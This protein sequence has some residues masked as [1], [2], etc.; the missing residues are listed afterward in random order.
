MLSI[1]TKKTF[2]ERKEECEE[3]N[4]Q[5]PYRILHSTPV[6]PGNSNYTSFTQ[7]KNKNIIAK[8]LENVHIEDY[9]NASVNDNDIYA[10]N[11]SKKSYQ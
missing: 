10:D 5:K 11:A 1:S 2:A 4:N 3:E 9:N 7:H 6:T 8:V